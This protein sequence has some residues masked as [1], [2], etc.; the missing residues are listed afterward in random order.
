MTERHLCNVF[1]QGRIAVT[2]AGTPVPI[3]PSMLSTAQQN[4][5]P[6][7]CQVAKVEVWPDPAAAGKVYVKNS[8]GTILATLPVAA[9]GAVYPWSTPDVEGNAIMPFSGG[10]EFIGGSIVNMNAGAA[11]VSNLTQPRTATALT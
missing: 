1:P 5:L 10:A 4:Q 2:A 7:T 3:V 11:S 9:A 8:A 6:L